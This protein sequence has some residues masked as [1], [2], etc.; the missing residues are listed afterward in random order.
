MYKY[1]YRRHGESP[2]KQMTGGGRKK[3]AANF[4]QNFFNLPLPLNNNTIYNDVKMLT[5]EQ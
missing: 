5:P 2:L 4:I 3:R 1:K